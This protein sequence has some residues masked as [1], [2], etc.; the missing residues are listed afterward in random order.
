MPFYSA[1]FCYSDPIVENHLNALE[2]TKIHL[3]ALENTKILSLREIFPKDEGQ[4]SD[5]L[6]FL[7]GQNKIL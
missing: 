2:N 3:N 6:K 4:L 1:L 5:R 7:A